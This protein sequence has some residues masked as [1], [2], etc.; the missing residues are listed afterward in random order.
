VTADRYGIEI[1]DDSPDCACPDSFLDNYIPVV[2]CPLHRH[3]PGAFDQA[4]VP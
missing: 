3:L 1:T 4:V 2:E